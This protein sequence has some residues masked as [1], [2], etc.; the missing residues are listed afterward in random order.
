ME[1]SKVAFACLHAAMVKRNVVG[2]VR[3]VIRSTSG[4]RIAAMIPQSEE[5]DECGQLR[6]DGFHLVPLP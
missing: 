3:L 1:G 5:Y 4:P 2:I 6:P